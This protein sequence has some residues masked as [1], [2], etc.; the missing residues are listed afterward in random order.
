M[1][2]CVSMPF[3][4][5]RGRKGFRECPGSGR[6]CLAQTTG[7]RAGPELSRTYQEPGDQ[8]P[9]RFQNTGGKERGRYFFS[10]RAPHIR[11]RCWERNTLAILKVTY[12]SIT[13]VSTSCSMCCGPHIV[14]SLIDTPYCYFS[15]CCGPHN[16][17]YWCASCFKLLSATQVKS[18]VDILALCFDNNL[19]NFWPAHSPWQADES[20][21]WKPAAASKSGS[22]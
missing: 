15:N 9:G 4:L 20:T 22:L 14:T 18:F 8:E 2:N 1:Q 17:C 19:R 10:Y 6:L 12:L 16:A 5:Y 7:S 21:P 13:H 11:T 3:M